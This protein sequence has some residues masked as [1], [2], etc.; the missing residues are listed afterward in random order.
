MH[1]GAC[2][3]NQAHKTK[4]GVLYDLSRLLGLLH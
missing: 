1:L 3:R 2:V 4:P